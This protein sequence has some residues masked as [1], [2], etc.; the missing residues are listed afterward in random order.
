MAQTSEALEQARQKGLEIKKEIDR[1][2]RIYTLGV[3]K[4][5]LDYSEEKLREAAD[6][7]ESISGWRDAASLKEEALK[8][9]EATHRES[10]Y[11]EAMGLI[12]DGEETS[13]EKAIEKLEEICGYKDSLIL[14]KQ[15][16]SMLSERKSEAR[17]AADEKKKAEEC[18]KRYDEQY[19]ELL[20][21]SDD[22]IARLAVLRRKISIMDKERN[23]AAY[24]WLSFIGIVIS[25]ICYVLMDNN[26]TLLAV[27]LGLF[28][29][30]VV[31]ALMIACGLSG[32]IKKAGLEKERKEAAK[33][34]E[35]IEAIPSF[36]EYMQKSPR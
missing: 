9:A 5:Q 29:G 16:E 28:V 11:K 34:A 15:A 30:P 26:S 14:L 35:Q 2:N 32:V 18:R 8:K 20:R 13:L 22:A 1:K 19:S 23:A 24:F 10:V 27:R 12:R 21:D 3:G 4:L 17:S 7:F 25:F 31:V 33:K 36:E 6:L